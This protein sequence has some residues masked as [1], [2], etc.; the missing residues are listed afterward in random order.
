[1]SNGLIYHKY[2]YNKSI[3]DTLNDVNINNSTPKT[4]KHMIHAKEKTYDFIYNKKYRTVR[5][6]VTDSYVNVFLKDNSEALVRL[7]DYM[8][9]YININ[10]NFLVDFNLIREYKSGT[11]VISD[12]PL[13]ATETISL[14]FKGGT[15]MNYIFREYKKKLEEKG[16]LQDEQMKIMFEKINSFFKVSDTDMTL[17]IY[18]NMGPSRYLKLIN[19]S[20]EILS[21]ILVNLS[22]LLDIIYIYSTIDELNVTELNELNTVYFD[23]YV[24]HTDFINI[25]HDKLFDEGVV[26]NILNNFDSKIY[27]NIVDL[28]IEIDDLKLSIE[29]YYGI[30][31]TKNN[32][33]P[34]T[35]IKK[36][37]EKIINTNKYTK[38]LNEISYAI[39]FINYL[40]CLRIKGINI[41]CG[42]YQ[43]DDLVSIR[44]RIYKLGN[45][46]LHYK[47]LKLREILY[48][49]ETEGQNKIKSFIQ[50]SLKLIKE[51][52]YQIN[53]SA[54]K[55][56]DHIKS[57]HGIFNSTIQ[58]RENME[59]TK[60]FVKVPNEDYYYEDISLFETNSTGSQKY[61]LA[62]ENELDNI[63]LTIGG[64]KHFLLS[65]KDNTTFLYELFEYDSNSKIFEHYK[66]KKIL[67]LGEWPQQNIIINKVNKINNI[68]NTSDNDIK[69][70]AYK[71]KNQLIIND[72]DIKYHT[73]KI[74]TFVNNDYSK[75][76]R[77]NNNN[78]IHYVSVNKSIDVLYD[79]QRLNFDLFRI[80][81]NTNIHNLL[82]NL[83][84]KISNVQNDEV[85]IDVI[86]TAVQTAS[87][88]SEVLDV[89]IPRDSDTMHITSLDIE[90]K[91]KSLILNYYMDGSYSQII[92]YNLDTHIFDLKYILY[93]QTNCYM[94]WLDIKY[95]KRLYRLFIIIGIKMISNKKTVEYKQ[96]LRDIIDYLSILKINDDNVFKDRENIEKYFINN[97]KSKIGSKKDKQIEQNKLLYEHDIVKKNVYSPNILINDTLLKI[98]VNTKMSDILLGPESDFDTIIYSILIYMNIFNYFVNHNYDENTLNK[99]ISHQLEL[100]NKTMTFE[101]DGVFTLY[102]IYKYF[103]D[104]H[105]VCMDCEQIFNDNNLATIGNLIDVKI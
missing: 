41:D 24:K 29:R 32:N 35:K 105:N 11:E 33:N 20:G 99:I 23:K 87:A 15:T 17:N 4:F 71:S 7:I 88:P 80:K 57:N 14:I 30:R 21:L 9:S 44:N 56:N 72:Y 1:M 61:L 92:M 26:N 28:K 62:T 13:L 97:I 95:K 65:C 36:L 47:F 52:T 66:L 38:D 43:T 84:Y 82:T 75:P 78:N 59:K 103:I 51:T 31:Y 18:T 22:N 102:N 101:T 27:E 49:D 6:C 67:N 54:K 69:D 70:N 2:I 73:P 37:I 34:S 104:L 91:T 96:A 12:F 77:Q 45:F 79:N 86:K 63:N 98:A 90:K 46:V 64:R 89:S 48:K 8:Y 74:R 60:Q 25:A 16:L 19:I 5:D 94:P 83:S 58:Y 93:T 81:F 53:K 10:L 55:L 3:Y 40:V 100:Y 85:N 39:E 68:E 76:E 50:E 42:G